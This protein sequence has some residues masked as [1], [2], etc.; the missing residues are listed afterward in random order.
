MVTLNRYLM[1][2]ASK[3]QVGEEKIPSDPSSQM[4]CTKTLRRVGDENAQ[5]PT[6]VTLKGPEGELQEANMG[7]RPIKVPLFQL[8]LLPKWTKHA[9]RRVSGVVQLWT[10]NQMG[11]E[12]LLQTAIIYPPAASQRGTFVTPKTVQE[13][14]MVKNRDIFR[15]VDDD[16]YTHGC[17]GV[18]RPTAGVATAYTLR[19]PAAA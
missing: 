7:A 5:S 6:M 13:T 15:L 14:R 18:A 1:W 2:L 16:I 12:T 11:N 19:P 3:Y 17:G 9:N 4:I 8:V 10:L